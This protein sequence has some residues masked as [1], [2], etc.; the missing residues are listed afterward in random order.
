M[1]D[2]QWPRYIV[3]HQERV[4]SPHRYAGSVHAPDAEMAML[5]AR[6]VFVRRPE[7]FSLWVVR[8]TLVHALTAEELAENPDAQPYPV[9]PA[10]STDRDGAAAPVPAPYY[11]FQK[12]GHK[13]V[14]EHVG[15]VDATSPAEAMCSALKAFPNKK[16][17]VWWVFP[18]RAVRESTPED[19]EQLFQIAE[20][21]LYRDQGQYH[22]VAALQRIKEQKEWEQHASGS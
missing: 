5:N 4:G 2:T 18:V 10:P 19:I 20:T 15:E 22:T 14:H 12:I 11:V 8:A 9:D 17:T 13:K 7:C 21:K 3:L 6:D 16:A 1:T